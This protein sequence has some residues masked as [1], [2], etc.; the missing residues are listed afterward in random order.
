LASSPTSTLSALPM[1]PVETP[2]RYIQGNAADTRG[3]FRM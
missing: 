1:S 3:D 2:R